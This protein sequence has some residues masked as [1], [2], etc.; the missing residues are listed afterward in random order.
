MTCASC[1]T[2]TR[3][4]ERLEQH[5]D[6]TLWPECGQTVSGLARV[7]ADSWPDLCRDERVSLVHLWFGLDA[8]LLEDRPEPLSKLPDGLLRLPDIYTPESHLA[9]VRLSEP[10]SL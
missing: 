6:T 7:E 1:S 3:S 8:Q 2:P 9:L 4:L 5:G 10:T